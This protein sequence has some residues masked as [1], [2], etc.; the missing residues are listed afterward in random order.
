MRNSCGPEGDRVH[1]WVTLEE[2]Q[3]KS[4]GRQV[5]KTLEEIEMADHSALID[6]K[7]YLL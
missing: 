6:A 7:V 2:I 5:W 1:L 4:I 3:N